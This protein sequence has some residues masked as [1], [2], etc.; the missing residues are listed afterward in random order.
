MTR[1]TH[2]YYADRIRN[3]L[4]INHVAAIYDFEM[5]CVILQIGPQL[6]VRNLISREK[7]K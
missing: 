6:M 4:Y 1:E 5:P 2:R 7:I 3:D